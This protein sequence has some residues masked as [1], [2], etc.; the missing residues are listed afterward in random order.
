MTPA[1]RRVATVLLAG[2]TAGA[3]CPPG[4]APADFAR[5]LAEDVIDLVSDLAGVEPAVA[6]EPGGGA[7]A[8]AMTWPGTAVIEV[9]A[10]AGPIDVLTVLAATGPPSAG[11]TTA[12]PAAAASYALV[13]AADAP[14]L[15]GLVLAKPF[16]AL[17]D[18][19]VAVVPADGGGLVVLAARLPVPGWL[20]ATDVDLDTRD[21]MALLHAAAP[22]RRDLAVTPRWHRLRAPADLARLDPGLQGWDA[23]RALLSG[24]R[25][26]PG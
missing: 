24:A 14:D 9:P 20:A 25:P 18:A 21:A 7:A 4:V 10:D 2:P 1:E 17:T 22:R 12:G 13:V 8:R 16:S 26:P 6:V 11:D 23:T 15:P 19:D 5:A 3:A